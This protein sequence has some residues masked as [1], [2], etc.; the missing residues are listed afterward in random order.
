MR[1]VQ[2][3]PSQNQPL[4]GMMQPIP[5]REFRGLNTFD[6][7]S[8]EDVYFTE[9]QNLTT[10]DYPAI[11]TRPGYTSIGTFGTR[12]LGMGVWRGRELHAVFNDGTWR[13]WSGSAW[14]TLASG[15]NTSAEWS[16]TNF[17]GNLDG[18]NLIG[19]NGVD[20][21]RRYNGSS[22]SVLSGAPTNG[23][24]ITTYQNRLWCAV[25]NELW[26]SAL[27]QPQNWNTFAGNQQ[28]SYRKTIESSHGED[29]NM[30][31]GSLYRLTIGMPSSIHLLMGG[32]P[33]DFNSRVVTDDEGV[34][35]NN[36]VTAREGSLSFM[37]KS[38]I[39]EYSAAALPD[40]GFS[41]LVRTFYNNIIITSAAGSDGKRSF[42]STAAGETLVYDPRIGVWSRWMLPAPTCFASIDQDLYIGTASGQVLR[43]GGMVDS[44]NPI[45]WK[46]VTK[47]FTNGS[48]AQ[49]QRWL[50][51]WIVAEMATGSTLN[52]S[53]S[54]QA[55]GE[56]WD[57]V[58][59]ITASSSVA[60]RIIIPVRKFALE[61]T[62]RIK[63]EGTGWIRLHEIT[64]QVRQLPLY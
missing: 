14:T 18:V 40:K 55:S 7:Y 19:C 15:L 24:Y 44:S 41:E 61:N 21:M 47:P 49:K 12:V 60:Q 48:I 3:K 58:S 1:P 52:I 63:L 30:L 35:N 38:G 33:S 8:I 11:S 34:A 37:H 5:I 27:D 4:E 25:G 43:L 46:A 32:Q 9:M 57:L 36:A 54:S 10:D 22:V 26:S 53:L 6:P 20:S 51:M 31:S 56:S 50:K 28:D 29:I 13:R 42:F 45:T 16:F 17:D 23:K 2:Y 64:R 39:Y 62:V 59:S